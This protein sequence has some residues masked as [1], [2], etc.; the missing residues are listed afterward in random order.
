MKKIKILLIDHNKL[1]REG[2][3]QILK[4]Q[5]DMSVVGTHRDS[6]NI[7]EL[8]GVNKPDIVL[9][10]LGIR[11]PNSLQIVRLIRRN[12]LEIRIIVMY[13]IPLQEDI[14]GF[15]QEGVSGFILKDVNITEFLKTIRSVF[16]GAKVLPL[17]LIQSL[18]SQ[19]VNYANTHAHPSTI[20]K[21]ISLTRREK[22]VIGFMI[23]GAT[24]KEIAQ[25]L[26]LSVSTIKYFVHNIFGKMAIHSRVK[27]IGHTNL[28]KPS[29]PTLITTSFI[30]D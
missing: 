6:K 21:S 7:L 28:S 2:I 9:L 14:L 26:H 24:N 15:I 17:N 12:F 23:D 10:D 20:L 19:I 29:K 8:I 1:L 27:I 30:D 5:N 22:Q 25:L 13:L 18:F 3:A 16:H 4:N 11:S